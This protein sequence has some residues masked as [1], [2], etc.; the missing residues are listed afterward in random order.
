MHAFPTF[1]P[2]SPVFFLHRRRTNAVKRNKN[3]T[4]QQNFK[5]EQ[6]YKETEKK[7]EQTKKGIK[8]RGT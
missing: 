7:K 2:K 5:K 6:K 8:N 4:R 3:K 1:F